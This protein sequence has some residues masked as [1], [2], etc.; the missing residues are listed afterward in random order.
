MKGII[1]KQK[2]NAYTAGKIFIDNLIKHTDSNVVEFDNKNYC[3]N[4]WKDIYNQISKYKDAKYIFSGIDYFLYENVEPLHKFNI[5]L[6]MSA[7]NSWERL[8]DNRWR[9]YVKK[10]RPSIISLDDWCSKCVYEDILDVDD[11]QYI[12]KPFDTDI[13]TIK[14]YQEKKIWD[15]SLSGKPS[16]KDRRYYET[17]IPTLS[18]KLKFKFKR[19]GRNFS[20]EDY[21]R[22]LNKSWMSMSSVQS[23]PYYKNVYIGA[24]VP[25]NI[26]I[27][28]S[29]ACLF[30][31]KWG[32]SDIMGFKDGENCVLFENNNEIED[33]LKYYLD[34][35]DVLE[36]IIDKGYQL[37]HNKHTPEIHIKQYIKDLKEILKRI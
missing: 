12:W 16:Y 17:F 3:S 4:N 13:S 35:K 22:N 18:E 29:K 30:T 5:P 23:N 14:D 7:G 9:K 8:K 32:D 11:L 37:V 31:K 36:K 28:G 19:L 33:K 27:A 21:A 20:F 34:N 15:V 6:I 2:Y 1:L 24:N 25:K 26:E 10:H